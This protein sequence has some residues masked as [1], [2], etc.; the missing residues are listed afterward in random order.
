ME[1]P[2]TGGKV[3][4][5]KEP[6]EL[7]FRN[8]TVEIVYHSWQCIDTG[9]LFTTDELDMLNINQVHNKYREKHNI[10][11]PDQ[12]RETRRKYGLSAT[13]MSELLGFGV[14]TYRNYESG[15]VPQASNGKLI[16]L[17]GNPEE[18]LRLVEIS[19]ALEGK[20][21]QNLLS[22]VEQMIEEEKQSEESSLKR[23]LSE[24]SR[25]PNIYTGYRELRLDKFCN[26]VIF[27][28]E[29]VQP[30]KTR[31]NK[32]MF[33]ADFLNYKKTGFSISGANY[34]AID[35]GPVPDAY[36][37]LYEFFNRKHFVQIEY[38]EFEGR[39][40]IGEKFKPQPNRPFEQELFEDAELSSL[41]FVSDYFV[42]MNTQDLIEQSHRE[43]A[44]L[45]KSKEKG[46]IEYN[47]AFNLELGNRN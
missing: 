17:A 46:L 9:E 23:L 45:D 28:A 10:P 41:Q 6:K 44:W 4:L 26:M 29:N 33:Y 27:F 22:R 31:L 24:K 38:H 13:K 20:N 25:Y 47:Y 2:F 35:L 5:V 34:A 36:D 39:E 37:M 40:N 3:K 19:D 1:S 15:E 11:F 14:N 43:K 18:F 21:R 12:I 16:K 32:L 42:E 30:F 8:E 7:E